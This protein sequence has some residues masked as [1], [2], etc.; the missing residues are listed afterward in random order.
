MIEVKISNGHIT[1]RFSGDTPTI[2][3]DLQII[4]ISVLMNLAKE[5]KN[6]YNSLVSLFISSLAD[7]YD[8]DI[9]TKEGSLAVS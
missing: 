9:I 7:N 8:I 4:C 3:K 1:T 5:D 6:K 2:L